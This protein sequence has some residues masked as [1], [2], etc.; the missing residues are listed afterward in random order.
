ML[1]SMPRVAQRTVTDGA[2]L[3]QHWNGWTNFLLSGGCVPFDYEPPVIADIVDQLR[4]D[5]AVQY[6]DVQ[7]AAASVEEFRKLPIERAM[8]SSFSLAHSAL[9]N[10]TSRGD[11][12]AGLWPG[13]MAPWVSFMAGLGFSWYRCCPIIF[14]SGPGVPGHYHMDES[15]VVAWQLHGTKVFCGL[16]EPQ[17][18][19]P[20]ASA[21]D[22]EWRQALR[23]PTALG[24]AEVLQYEMPPGSVLWN[25]PL[26]PHWVNAGD[27]GAV[28]ASLNLSHGGL[29]LDGA[30]SP[31]GAALEARYRDDSDERF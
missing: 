8:E 26:T 15:H 12:L 14:V 10:F 5:D 29:R 22:P 20:L 24:S 16:R 17:T 13:G 21:L 25:Q 1:R 28:A 27:D 11:L 18:W 23:R 9:T 31:Q 19:A 3:R 2:G 7:D 4:R 6:R 30:L